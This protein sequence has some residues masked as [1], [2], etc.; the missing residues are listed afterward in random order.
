MAKNSLRWSVE[1]HSK[2]GSFGLFTEYFISQRKV[3]SSNCEP[4]GLF[5]GTEWLE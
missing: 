4:S 1:V 2:E 5:L 3:E